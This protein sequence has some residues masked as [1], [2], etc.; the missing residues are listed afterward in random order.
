M[1]LNTSARKSNFLLYI[2]YC[3]KVASA[4]LVFIVTLLLLLLL[5]LLL[6]LFLKMFFIFYFSFFFCENTLHIN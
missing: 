6:F 5:L 4:L 2:F 1:A 3:T